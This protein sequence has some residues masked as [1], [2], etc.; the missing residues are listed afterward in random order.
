MIAFPAT[1]DATNG[2]AAVSQVRPK[3]R[4]L[5]DVEVAKLIRKE[6]KAAFPAVKFSVTSKSSIRINYTDGPTPAR[7][8]AIV[9]QFEGKGFDGM[10]DSTTYAGPFKYNGEWVQTYC[11]V[12]VSRDVSSAFA[13]R[14]SAAVAKHYGMEAPDVVEGW[15]KPTLDQERE[16]N[17]RTCTDWG[18]MIYRASRDR[19]TVTP[20]LHLMEA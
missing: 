10:T 15:V 6:L 7:V 18:T 11:Y 8:D 5:G 17:R 2:P 19:M 13:R 9:K 3:A 16:C 1:I 4:Q 14:L 12:F 20:K